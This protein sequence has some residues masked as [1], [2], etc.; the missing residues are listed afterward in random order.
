MTAIYG[1][2]STRQNADNCPTVLGRNIM[3]ARLRKKLTRREAETRMMGGDR[4]GNRFHK[5]E[6]M[7][8]EPRAAT[9]KLIAKALG[10]TVAS[11]LNNRG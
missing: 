10:V 8:V 7:G 11:L 6:A 9:L 3:R 1:V 2:P 4:L 5:Y